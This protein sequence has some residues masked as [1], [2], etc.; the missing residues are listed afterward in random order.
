MRK[1]IKDMLTET[2]NET[3]DVV[4]VLA[5]LAIAIGLGL[6]VWVVIRWIGPAPQAFDI[7]SFGIGIGAT[8]AGVGAALKMKPETKP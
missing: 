7:Q 3:V 5:L 1:H 8:F 2:D 6:Q 4:R